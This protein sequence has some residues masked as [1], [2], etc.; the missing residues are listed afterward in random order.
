M[1]VNF[2]P[3]NKNIHSQMHFSQLPRHIHQIQIKEWTKDETKIGEV[4]SNDNSNILM[5]KNV[6]NIGTKPRWVQ[7]NLWFLSK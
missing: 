1:E 2:N 4:Q 7:F 3:K 6:K 5:L